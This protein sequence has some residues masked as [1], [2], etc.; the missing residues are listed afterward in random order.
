[1]NSSLFHISQTGHCGFGAH[2]KNLKVL[3][4]YTNMSDGLEERATF[5]VALYHACLLMGGLRM[6]PVFIPVNAAKRIT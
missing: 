5:L 1:M 2:Y 3:V 6:V 4:R